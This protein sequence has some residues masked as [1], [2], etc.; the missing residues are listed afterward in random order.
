MAT[1]S[2]EVEGKSELRKSEEMIKNLKENVRRISV[3]VW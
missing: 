2:L 1:G 3:K